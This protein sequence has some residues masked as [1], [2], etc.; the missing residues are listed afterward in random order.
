MMTSPFKFVRALRATV[1]LFLLAGSVAPV[2]QAQITLGAQLSIAPTA[3]T[4]GGT[5]SVSGARLLVGGD[6]RVILVVA[7]NDRRTLTTVSNGDGDFQRNV[8]L[9]SIANGAY[10]LELTVDNVLRDSS[11]LRVLSPLA[12]TVT[13]TS[14]R[15]GTS[16]NFSVS[17]L[18]EGSLSLIY[19]GRVAFGPVNV[20]GGTYNGRLRI[21]TD[22]PAS[23]PAN[24]RVDAKNAIG[25]ITP[26]VGTRALSVQ[27]ANLSPFASVFNAAP[28]TSTPGLRQ[29]FNIAGSVAT[30]EANA[31][32]VSVE[33]F[34]TGANGQVIPMG[35]TAGSVLSNGSFNYQMM[36]P[37]VGTMSAGQA[38]GPGVYSTVTHFIDGNGLNQQLPIAQGN[39]SAAFDFDAAIDLNFIIRGSD[40]LRI[41]GARLELVEADLDTLYGLNDND[42]PVRLD[43]LQVMNTAT[44]FAG[45]DAVQAALG[46][47]ANI[48]RQYSDANG[49]AD[50]QFNL[51]VP[52][53]GVNVDGSGPTPQATIAP[54]E[55]CIPSPD[56][57]TPGM[58][59]YSDPAGLSFQVVVRAVHTGYGY[60]TPYTL[61]DGSSGE[62]EIPVVIDTRIDRYTG[63]ISMDVCAPGL[64]CVHRDFQRSA[65][66][67]LT[68][69]DLNRSGL[70]LGH[71][72][73]KGTQAG[74]GIEQA[75]EVENA[76]GALVTFKPIMDLTPFR[77]NAAFAPAQP[78]RLAEFQYNAGAGRPLREAKLRIF[79]NGS[80]IV[81]PMSRITGGSASC[82]GDASS[83]VWRAALPATINDGFRFPKFIYGNT[84][85]V[86]GYI[87]AFETDNNR[88]I[89]AFKFQFEP[90]DSA[91]AALAGTP[92][93]TINTDRPHAR[94]LEIAP[95]IPENAAQSA[96]APA[97]YNL[98]A[99]RS[100][101]NGGTDYEFCIPKSAGN[102]GALSTV[103]FDHQQFSDTPGS[104][105]PG[106][107]A[108]EAGKI[109][110]TTGS[111]SD[112][113]ETLFNHTI[114]IFRW[115]WGIPEL[116]SAEVFA[117]LAIKAE[118]MLKTKFD[119]ASPAT[120]KVDAGGRLG[121]GVWIGV[122]IDVLFGVLVD[123]GAA[124]YGG[125]QTELVTET[126]L[127]QVQ[128]DP[129]LLFTLDFSGWLEIGC[130]IPN[131]FDPTCYI[132]DI[133]E[134]FNILQIRNPS[135]CGFRNYRNPAFG[136]E[137]MFAGTSSLSW[138]TVPNTR[139]AASAQ[140]RV[141]PINPF[142]RDLQRAMYRTP[143]L[144]FD[145]TGNRM[146]LNLDRQGQLVGREGT[147]RTFG[148]P[149]VISSG[150]GIRDVAVAYFS[151]D[152]AVAVWAESRLPP[153]QP[154]PPL[155]RDSAASNQRLRYALFDGS[156]WGAPV[157]LTAGGFGEGQVKLARCRS[158]LLRGS[159]IE[160]VSLVF[161]RNTERTVG[162]DK[163]IFFAQF[164]GAR[165]TTP[166]QVDQSGTINITPSL[167]YAA[168]D[169]VVAWVR[170]APTTS[171]AAV[172]LT[173]VSRR[174]LALRIMDGRSSEE[175]S[176]APSNRG[177]AQPSIAGKLTGQLA[178]AFTT[179]DASSFIGTRQSLHLGER[180][181]AAGQSCP[182]TTWQVAD[183]HGRKIYVERPLL[184]LNGDGEAVVTYRGLAY[185]PVPGVVNP[186]DNL[187]D[188]DPVGIRTTRGELMQI[189]SA[190]QAA[191][192]R[193][194]ALSVNGATHY[195][196]AAA[197]DSLNGEVVSLSVTVSTPAFSLQAEQLTQPG[198]RSIAQTTA[199]D[200]GIQMTTLADLPE[201][202]VE[203]LST[204]ATRLAPGSTIPV[205]VTIANRGSAWNVD[206][207]HT[208]LVRLWWDTPQTRTLTSAS[209][210]L[211]SIAA[212]GR[213]ARTIQVS[214]PTP[215][216][217]DEKQALR[218]AIEVESEEGEIDGDNNESILA[219][220]GMP[221]PTALMA[222]SAPGTRF[223]NLVWNAPTDNRIA[224]YRVYVDDANGVAHPLG[225][226]FNKGWADLT[227]LYGRTRSYRVSTYSARGIESD[228]SEPVLAEPAPALIASSLFSDGFE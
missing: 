211:G 14:P 19:D 158:L 112:P 68:L 28:T 143:A 159:C 199:L 54:T 27:V 91:I 133:E 94:R 80:A 140:G 55:T 184:N 32:E 107:S 113:W 101:V 139:S 225:S 98:P 222:L 190:L 213:S 153:G 144:A 141:P 188:N 39:L 117:D 161:Q 108:N 217:V 195:Q 134:N 135:G 30:N 43:G 186:Q 157:N 129:C 179:G 66:L 182:F 89:S 65:N 75:I 120:T 10:T 2:L 209:F 181:C 29:R 196:P 155:T 124:I 85:N 62:R 206:A 16:V 17:G 203:S 119:P 116:F 38:S 9:P 163:H 86:V 67:T 88:G 185:G 162:G 72:Y 87:E 100:S 176:V 18:T 145:G 224:G 215:F 52:T 122:D 42:G 212:G 59:T 169:P 45:S 40:G 97:E 219:V 146:V 37:Q 49:L 137:N 151:T 22:R 50:F 24:V 102:C 123:A 197:Y 93:I 41:N 82:A 198:L 46:C 114:P 79:R 189:R 96:A 92:G 167:T 64:P 172:S 78:V 226:S 204:S 174:F 142:P 218:V 201:L 48:Q 31:N 138:P 36:T 111:S 180:T 165:W 147:L 131:P 205:T 7:A 12:I 173:D 210:T 1:L 61:P 109:I 34:W 53:G 148:T 191:P 47:P 73:F 152:R 160:K 136:V 70:L 83:E 125:L 60:V 81:V 132:P 13:P 74:T 150:F 220:G 4:A 164:D 57:N 103:D 178:I 166:V 194:V 99:K 192:A 187:F 84:P 106:P 156:R 207:T 183:E 202:F 105:P 63:A 171:G 127:S 44:Q 227:A 110:A 58:C 170:Y 221:V 104:Q 130:P 8:V 168:G 223:V 90:L 21:P 69:P 23:L 26:R 20:D 154:S 115:Y 25:R 126:T 33:Y 6:Y 95:A 76:S 118:Y 193:P 208:A 71:P 121:V 5:I 35:A 216:G 177:I 11:T 3:A 15:A 149:Q 200:D 51:D 128:I 56:I 175:I 228:L 214:V 77:G